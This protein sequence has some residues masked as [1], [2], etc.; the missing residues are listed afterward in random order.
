MELLALVA[1]TFLLIWV[2]RE[3]K[4]C[5]KFGKVIG[6]FTVLIAVGLMICTTYHSTWGKR[7][8]KLEMKKRPMIHQ[9]QRPRINRGPGGIKVNIDDRKAPPPGDK[10]TPGDQP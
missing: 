1:G 7:E 8:Y 10:K 6:Y 9:G 3:G 4:T 5:Q 2:Y